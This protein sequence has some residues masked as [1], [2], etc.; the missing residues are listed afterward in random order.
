MHIPR[1]SVT[2]AAVVA[3]FA[4]AAWTVVAA[5]QEAPRPAARG[6]SQTAAPL[7]PLEESWLRWPLPA[8]EKTYEQIDGQR[9]K[10]YVKEITAIS[11]R[12][13]DR[14]EQ[15]WG[16]I[17]G[18]AADDET[19][20]WLAEKF[21]HAGV[22]D[23]RIQ[24]LD[25]PPQWYPTSWVVSALDKGTTVRLES[26]M[27][28]MRSPSGTF[29]LEPV[30]VGLGTEADFAQRDVKGKAAFIFGSPEPGLW[31][32]SAIHDGALQ[33]AEQRGAAAV[34]LAVGL[35]GNMRMHAIRGAVTVP[36]FSV[37]F[38]DFVAVRKM[39][40]GADA[41]PGPRPRIKIT[42]DAKVIPGLKTANVWGVI[43]GMTDEK[44]I[45]SAHRDGYFEGAADNASGLAT[46]VGLAEYYTKLPKERRLRTIML[47]GTPGHHGTPDLG[48]KWIQEHRDTELTKLALYINGEHT[49]AGQTYLRGPAIRKANA[50]NAFWWSLEG[51]PKLQA[52]VLSAFRTFGIAT[53]AE[54]E[55][56]SPPGATGDYGDS[57]TIG[58]VDAGMFYHTEGETD[59]TIPPYGLEAST[60][61]FAKIIG[62]AGKLD[63]KALKKTAASS[64]E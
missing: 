22:Q 21:R 31:S 35:P 34:F 59:D 61:A 20:Q 54:P 62:E 3:L 1:L 43:P 29:D 56:G 58:L 10:S 48:L 53:Y 45:V 57:A 44:V 12:S 8:T 5:P 51:S 2:R 36:A 14:G 9:L 7:V 15:W 18:M 28:G 42:L 63:L 16:R 25:L 40:E 13:R 52:I 38:D 26:V 23:V 6:R 24:S 41:R 46:I 19:Q 32:S 49:A 30:Y 11:R 55:S 50:A 27:P 39:I 37:G 47:V 4:F 17:Q 60:R 64:H 33:R